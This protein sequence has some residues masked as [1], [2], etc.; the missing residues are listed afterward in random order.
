MKAEKTIR[1]LPKIRQQWRPRSRAVTNS[2]RELLTELEPV[3]VR[4]L[5]AVIAR[6][7]LDK[8]RKILIQILR[9]FD[10]H[11]RVNL[12]LSELAVHVDVVLV[13]DLQ[14]LRPHLS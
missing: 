7:P 10:L 11:V 12:D 13:I 2:L 14:E 9:T 3:L 5:P 1:V 6:E 4:A 8:P